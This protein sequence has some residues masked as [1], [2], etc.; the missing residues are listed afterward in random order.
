M[1][2]VW[3]DNM[4]LFEVFDLIGCYAAMV[5]SY[6]HFG[7]YD[8]FRNSGNLATN[9]GYTTWQ[10]TDDRQCGGNVLS[11]IYLVFLFVARV[12]HTTEDTSSGK[13]FIPKTPRISDYFGLTD[14]LCFQ[15]T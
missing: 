12:Q 6:R 13:L 2:S 5:V 3:S 10:K 14:P 8:P 9:Q 11:R 7:T 4:Y 1:H 15:I